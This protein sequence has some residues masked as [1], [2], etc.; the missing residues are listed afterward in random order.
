MRLRM[1][2]EASERSASTEAERGMRLL[3]RPRLFYQSL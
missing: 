2:R 1:F 3:F